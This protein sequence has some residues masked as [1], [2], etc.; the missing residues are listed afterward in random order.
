MNS[1]NK[2]NTSR[3]EEKTTQTKLDELGNQVEKL[4]SRT[5]ESIKKVIDKALAARNT[6]LTIRVNDESNEKLGMLVEAGLFKSR[7]ESAVFLIQEGIKKQ[8]ELFD[9]IQTKL[10]KID[11]I[12]EELR[13][14]VS[15]EITSKEEKAKK[16]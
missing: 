16:P 4:A 7:S 3:S 15:E 13:H 11:K 6:V 5:A 9:K 1:K 2:E 12:K 8:Q 10:K 14:I